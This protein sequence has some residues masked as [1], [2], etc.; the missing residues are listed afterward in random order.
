MHF[1]SVNK[2]MSDFMI[3]DLLIMLQ[4]VEAY[5]ILEQ[6]T[7]HES[8]NFRDIQPHRVHTTVLCISSNMI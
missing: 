4:T 7:G 5:D 1:K 6:M 8:V 3:H 2:E